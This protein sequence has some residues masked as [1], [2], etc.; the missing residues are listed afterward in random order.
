MLMRN[1]LAVVVLLLCVVAAGAED[2]KADGQKKSL[3]GKWV[4]DD[5]S[6]IPL[7]FGADETVKVGFYQEGGKWVLAEGK[8]TLDEKGKIKIT[9]MKGGSTLYLTY[10][11]DGDKI[12]GSHGPRPKV[13]WKK[14][15]EE[16][17]K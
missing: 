13:E 3:V 1:G 9:A 12:T 15:P 17:K 6:K 10:T 8:F 16:K 4:S 2:K 7:E 5:D 11:L 14:V